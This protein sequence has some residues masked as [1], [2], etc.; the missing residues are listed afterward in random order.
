MIVMPAIDV[1][2]AKVVRLKQGQLQEETVYGSD[3]GAVARKW[4]DEGARRLHVVD[5][6]AAVSGSFREKNLSRFR[7][8]LTPVYEDVNR[9]GRD[10]FISE[11]GFVYRTLPRLLFGSRVLSHEV[12]MK[13]PPEGYT[14]EDGKRRG[15]V[16]S[17]EATGYSKIDVNTDLAS[18]SVTKPWI[19]SCPANCFTLTTPNGTFSSFRVLF[20]QNLAALGSAQR[21]KALIQTMKEVEEGKLRFNNVGCVGCATCRAIGPKE[22]I[23]FQHERGGEGVSYRFG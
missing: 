2:G 13:P 3:P 10:S 20:Q 6:D 17:A 1:R 11:S 23:R 9:S 7:D 15:L 8:L 22:T 4:A 5:L 14:R 16:S 19:P 21:K 18:S 12:K